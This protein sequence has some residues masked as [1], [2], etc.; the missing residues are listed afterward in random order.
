[1]DNSY[2]SAA[3]SPACQRPADVG[4]PETKCQK[5]SWRQKYQKPISAIWRALHPSQLLSPVAQNKQ[6]VFKK[7]QQSSLAPGA[8]RARRLCPMTCNKINYCLILW[9]ERCSVLS[10]VFDLQFVKKKRKRFIYT[11]LGTCHLD[12]MYICNIYSILCE[13]CIFSSFFLDYSVLVH[14]STETINSNR[15]TDFPILRCQTT[16]KFGEL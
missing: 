8:C 2:V 7:I 11:Q 1:M 6:M 16:E 10:F 12:T 15:V 13:L 14:W 4:S 5:E 9:N 3:T